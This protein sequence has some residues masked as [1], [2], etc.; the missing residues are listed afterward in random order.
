M[1]GKSQL[2]DVADSLARLACQLIVTGLME[3]APA[4]IVGT[5]ESLLERNL[6]TKLPEG[7]ER[8]ESI[9]EILE[10]IRGLAQESQGGLTF[11]NS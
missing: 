11:S 10:G 2:A 4:G 8:G 7:S 9:L 5:T 3:I 1:E 6:K